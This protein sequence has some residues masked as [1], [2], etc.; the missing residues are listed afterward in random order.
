MGAKYRQCLDNS[1]AQNKEVSLMH[2]EH[3][4][5]HTHGNSH[6]HEHTHSYGHSH[7]H[8]HGNAHPHEHSG[9]HS[10][11]HAHSGAHSHGHA[12]GGGH[13]HEHGHGNGHPHEH[14]HAGTSG[15]SPKDVALLK[16]M[17]DHNKQHALE[18]AEAGGRLASSALADAAELINDAVHYFDHAN[19]KL[20]NAV[21]LICG[22]V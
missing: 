9:G 5:S 8:T 6:T 17:L 14:G 2:E 21:T 15:A 18:L 22:D 1:G 19:E 16:Y 20:E 7:E 3:D 4:H 10:Q 11:E 13:M 12:H